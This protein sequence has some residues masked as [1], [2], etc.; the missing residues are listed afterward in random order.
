MRIKKIGLM[1]G[2]TNDRTIFKYAFRIK[3]NNTSTI[4]NVSM[5][6]VK[7]MNKQQYKLK[8]NKVFERQLEIRKIIWKLISKISDMEKLHTSNYETIEYLLDVAVNNTK[9][10]DSVEINGTLPVR[11]KVETKGGQWVNK[12][13]YI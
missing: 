4:Y 8:L 12:A 1:I 3:G 7:K 9:I 13:Q 5:D 11:N 10:S 6:W 2:K